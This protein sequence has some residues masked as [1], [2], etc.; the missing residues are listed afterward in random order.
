MNI[1][2]LYGKT[3]KELTAIF[4]EHKWKYTLY[5]SKTELI[6]GLILKLC[7]N[8]FKK[9]RI[10]KLKA[11][12]EQINQLRVETGVSPEPNS[13]EEESIEVEEESIDESAQVDESAQADEEIGELVD[14]I[15]SDHP[16]DSITFERINSG[17]KSDIYKSHR[18]YIKG[19]YG[20]LGTH[21]ER[22]LFHGTD[23]RNIESIVNDDLLLT[24]IGK[25]GTAWG[26]GIYFSDDLKFASKYS[27]GNKKYVLLCRVHVGDIVL[28][29]NTMLQLPVD[30]YTNKQYDTAVNHI[31]HPNIFV[32]F[33]NSTYDIIGFLEITLG[34]G[35]K[36]GKPLCMGAARI[37]SHAKYFKITHQ[38][39]GRSGGRATDIMHNGTTRD[40]Y[41]IKPDPKF[42][43]G[44][45]VYDCR[46][47]PWCSLDR[48]PLTVIKIHLN[49]NGIYKYF[50]GCDHRHAKVWR[51]FD[52]EIKLLSEGPTDVID[53][54]ITSMSVTN[55]STDS[56]CIYFIPK[57]KS[58]YMN[59]VDEFT[60]QGYIAPGEIKKI[61]TWVG[62]EFACATKESIIKLFTVK[63][64][65]EC[66]TI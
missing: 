20:S 12:K 60:S 24:C 23:E 15:R 59:P 21:G 52:N 2:S 51:A 57:G 40:G 58:I 45:K 56:I 9:S 13:I 25:H 62:H 7:F 43:V 48:K 63:S 37:A 47:L 28:G 61:K 55:S 38:H 16:T 36:L 65:K 32:K 30:S 4:K 46:S 49:K 1:F 29:N 27:S 50:V 26:K 18:T 53:P 42:K 8:E 66:I 31:S 6:N 35:T 5:K 34:E 64:P 11:L 54:K 17:Y 22:L 41:P 10:E 14:E 19:K 33:K 39:T 44:D 3:V